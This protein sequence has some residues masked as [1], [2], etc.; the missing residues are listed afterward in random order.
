MLVAL[1][2]FFLKYDCFYQ[3]VNPKPY[4]WLDL[5][6]SLYRLGSSFSDYGHTELVKQVFQTSIR[7]QP[8]AL[9]FRDLSV[10]YNQEGR[11]W[12]AAAA[13]VGSVR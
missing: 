10:L 6:G 12:M 13:L 5:A 3:T 2:F 9:A 1:V 4:P 11:P 7:A 8:S